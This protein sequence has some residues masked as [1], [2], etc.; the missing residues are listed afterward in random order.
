MSLPCPT[1]VH[2]ACVG[3]ENC[4]VPLT[5]DGIRGTKGSRGPGLEKATPGRE[6]TRRQ[7]DPVVHASLPTPTCH[8]SWP[9]SE[10]VTS[11]GDLEPQEA[12]F[13]SAA[14]ASS[15]N[16]NMRA[17]LCPLGAEVKCGPGLPLPDWE[18]SGTNLTHILFFPKAVFLLFLS[19]YFPVIF[20][21]KKLAFDNGQALLPGSHSSNLDFASLTEAHHLFTME[22]LILSVPL[23]QRQSWSQRDQVT[24]LVL[25]FFEWS[26]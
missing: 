23:D 26:P 14:E 15:L 19:V 20:S 24:S 3:V 11:L 17:Q 1:L 7:F 8:C 25:M 13:H 6:G 22:L 12:A 9:E 10:L 18:L 2:S 21:Q 16:S 5:L 4:L